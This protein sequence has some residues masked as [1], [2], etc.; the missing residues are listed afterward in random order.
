MGRLTLHTCELLY[1]P[2]LDVP[3]A[4]AAVLVDEEG[5]IH[6]VGKRADVQ[7]DVAETCHHQVLMPGVVNAHIHVTDGFRPHTVPGGNGLVDW[8]GKLMPDRN[9]G[10]SEGEREAGI[11]AMLADI[12]QR[13][14]VAIGEVVNNDRTLDAIRESGLYCRFIFE[15]IG[16]REDRAEAALEIADSLETRIR[17]EDNVRIRYANGVH[18]PYSVSPK[19][20][21]AA[22]MRS[23]FMGRHFYQHL[24][25]D[26]DERELYEYGTGK[27]REF[28]EKIGAW[29]PSWNPPGISPIPFYDELGILAHEMVVVHLTD[30]TDEEIDLLANREVK[31]ILSPT[32]NLHI[33]GRLPRV[34]HIAESGMKIALGT[35]G[36]G[37]NPDMDVFS[38]AGLLKERYPGIPAGTWLRALTA[39]GA[40]IL[41]FTELGRIREKTAPGLVSVE[42]SHLGD[43]TLEECERSV[44]LR[45]VSRVRVV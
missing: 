40:D 24:A 20:M 39:G 31:A 18:A 12:R 16:F 2:D 27:W 41:Q 35:D 26:P 7:G 14:T 15:L 4:D 42:V 32:S 5:M 3:L 28:S 36:R 45:A 9:A 8:V 43:T 34:E 25:E 37:S 44:L 13:G 6:G 33:T 21:K 22:A 30:A 38:E 11:R 1:S 29:E 17:E 19:L 23:R 10:L